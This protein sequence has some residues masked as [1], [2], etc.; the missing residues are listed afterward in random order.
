MKQKTYLAI[1]TQKLIFPQ[2][3]GIVNF[4]SPEVIAALKKAGMENEEIVLVPTDKNIVGEDF[5]GIAAEIEQ[6]FTPFP[7]EIKLAYKAGRRVRVTSVQSKDGVFFAETKPVTFKKGNE[8]VIAQLFDK[9]VETY[10]L[11]ISKTAR[12]RLPL[13]KE[14]INADIDRIIGSLPVKDKGDFLLNVNTEDRLM[15]FIKALNEALVIMSVDEVVAEKVKEAIDDNQREYYIREQIKA[16]SE[17][18]GDDDEIGEYLDKID[19]LKA[20]DAIKEKLRKEANRIRRTA[21]ASPEMALLKNYLDTVLELPWGVYT[22]DNTDLK[23]AEKVLDEDHF[24]I[25]KVKERLIE[26]LAVRKLSKDGRSPIICLVGPPGIG[27]TSIAQSIARAMNK[28]YVRLSFGGVRDEAEIRGHRKTYIGAMPGRIIT[29]IQTAGSM[30]PVFLMDEIDKMASDYKGD[31]AS[32]LLEVLDPEQ[33]VNF[34]DHFLEL[35][36]D[37]SKVLFIT[38]ANSLDTISRPLLDRMEIIEMSG[39]T[40]PEK[41]EIAKRHLIRKA[42]KQ[43]GIQD[44]WITIDDSA[45]ERII[46]DYTRESGVRGLE[47]QIN[48][49][50]RKVA[51]RFVD[52][53]DAQPVVITSENLTEYLGEPKYFGN[54]VSAEDQIGVVNG[55]AWTAVGGDTLSIEVALTKGK[56]DIVI[57]GNL[58]DVMKESARIAISY[59]RSIANEL[60]LS[61]EFFKE[62]DI[63]IHVPEGATPKDGP[64][65]GITIATALASALSNRKV[66]HSVAMTGELTL[67]GKVL[68]IGGLKEKT[69]AAVRAGIKKVYLPEENRKDYNELPDI[70]KQ[71]LEFNFV[72]NVTTVIRGVLL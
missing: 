56:G 44:D 42:K 64:S 37:L 72:S 21:P 40:D 61:P 65:A 68:P 54:M 17:E 19:K 14:N 33:N 27:K 10:D 29:G 48:A 13:T 4:N 15:L 45:V 6:L 22:E 69:L 16:L 31:P 5:L 2:S 62:N 52:D 55:L 3:S 58:G 60:N 43:N 20:T 9:A 36:F 38:T 39:Y 8:L 51:R 49:I 53:P 67:R 70:V 59:C 25:K 66:D 30:N 28:K 7:F 34:R 26:A 63:H 24:G 18:I 71:K 41:I 1:P 32:A 23:E 57:T 35:P 50:M 46:H 12:R 11:F 47:K